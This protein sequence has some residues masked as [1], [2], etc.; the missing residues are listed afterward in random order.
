MQMDDMP[1]VLELLDLEEVDRDLYRSQQTFSEP[2]ALFGGQVAAQALMAA[3]RTVP[4]DRLPHSLHGYFL[5]RGDAGRRT[6]FRVDR[7]RDGRS[8]SAR[9]VVA[10]QGGEVIFNMSCSFHLG[11]TGPE[12]Q[13]QQAPEAEDPETLPDMPVSRL[14]SIQIRR[15]RQPFGDVP[16]PTLFWARVTTPAPDSPLVHA[17]LLTYLSDFGSGLSALDDARG[18]SGASIDH[19]VWFHRHGRLDDWVL[20]DLV[21]SSASCGRGWYT[22]AI[23]DRGGRHLASLTQEML[24]RSPLTDAGRG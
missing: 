9:R 24:F 14:S 4:E 11:Q 17:C 23:Y 1:G 16:W 18:A 8:F 12:V 5:R 6:V 10:L 21:P 22:G 7:D 15:P 19:A 3:G 2:H 13:S 20:T